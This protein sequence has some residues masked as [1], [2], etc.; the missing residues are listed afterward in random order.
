MSR[1][2]WPTCKALDGSWHVCARQSE[3]PLPERIAFMRKVSVQTR[4]RPDSH[5]MLTLIQTG[6][7]KFVKT[8]VDP[9]LPDVSDDR[10]QPVVH[11]CARS[12]LES[13]SEHEPTAANNITHSMA[14]EI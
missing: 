9:F 3:L 13:W 4:L 11:A 5:K 12:L 2:R 14:M 1:E 10:W 6:L 7:S 8:L